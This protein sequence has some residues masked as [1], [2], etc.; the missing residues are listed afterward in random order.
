MAEYFAQFPVMHD[1]ELMLFGQSF[2]LTEAQAA[3]MLKSG[4]ISETKPE[5]MTEAMHDSHVAAK[6]VGELF[7][8]KTDNLNAERAAGVAAEAQHKADVAQA[9]ADAAKVA[10]EGHD[11]VTAL[12]QDQVDAQAAAAKAKVE[13]DAAA[14]SEAATTGKATKVDI[15]QV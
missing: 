15:N 14:A 6:T 12:T 8:A 5:F 13:A 9:Q 1:G 2:E 3:P 7:E 10:A 4:A 11:G